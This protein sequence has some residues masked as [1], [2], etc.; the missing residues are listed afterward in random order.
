MSL[1]SIRALR[2]AFLDYH[3]KQIIVE[4]FSFSYLLSTILQLQ[5]K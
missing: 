4:K 2:Q 1:Q 5:A 3:R